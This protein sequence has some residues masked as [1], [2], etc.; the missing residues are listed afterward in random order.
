MLPWRPSIVLCFRVD[1]LLG[2]LPGSP[3]P[4]GGFRAIWK[5]AGA[6]SGPCRVGAT[7]GPSERCILHSS[8][9]FCVR[10]PGLQHLV[11]FLHPRG[12]RIQL[13][14]HT[15]LPHSGPHQPQRAAQGGWP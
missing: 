6:N 14:P 1:A 5:G 2:K 7:L 12:H 15:P 11:L 13:R 10:Q 8:F 3:A 4:V 9:H